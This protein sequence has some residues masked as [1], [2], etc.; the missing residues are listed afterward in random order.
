[1]NDKFKN[2]EKL[3]YENQI[4]QKQLKLMESFVI[5][6]RSNNLALFEENEKLK[7]LRKIKITLTIIKLLKKSIKA[8]K[9]ALYK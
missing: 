2:Y 7:K 9:N 1:M 3:F 8:I 4:L 5:E 6:T